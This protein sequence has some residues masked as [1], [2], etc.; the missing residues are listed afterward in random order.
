MDVCKEIKYTDKS[1]N[2]CEGFYLDGIAKQV[3]DAIIDRVVDR[4]QDALVINTGSEGAGK[5][6]ASVNMAVY[7]SS[8]TGRP[9]SVDNIFFK[10][11]D[12][13]KFAVTHKKQ[14]IIWDESALGGLASDWSNKNQKKL[15]SMLMVCRKLRHIFIFNIPRFYKMSS[16]IIERAHCLFY[17]FEDKTERPGN[18][19]II[20]KEGL[21]NLY[22]GW[23]RTGYA[24]YFNHKKAPPGHFAWVM[25]YLIDYE[26]YN[27]MKDNAIMSISELTN[28]PKTSDIIKEKDAKYIKNMKAL[29]IK[30]DII[31]KIMEISKTTLYR[32]LEPV[33][34]AETYY[35]PIDTPNPDV[36]GREGIGDKCNVLSNINTLKQ[37]EEETI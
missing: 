32:W 9:F 15:I 24:N 35:N 23:K 12:M 25:P 22:T 20:G 21:E 11:E 31:Q 4:E 36:L 7:M 5:S 33:P 18:F 2:S 17:M 3:C 6:G 26:K 19:I 10:L 37:G 29:G 14:I 16:S 28:E 30:N 13:I 34:S 1:G 27:T 8:V